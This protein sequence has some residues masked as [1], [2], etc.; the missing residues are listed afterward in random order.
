[1]LKKNANQLRIPK[2]WVD[3]LDL[4]VDWIVSQIRDNDKIMKAFAISTKKIAEDKN[5]SKVKKRL[6]M[7]VI[8]NE[9][10]D[11]FLVDFLKKKSIVIKIKNKLV[12]DYFIMKE[13]KNQSVHSKKDD[14]D[15][16]MKELDELLDEGCQAPK[17]FID[18]IKLEEYRSKTKSDN[19]ALMR[20]LY[21]EK[22]GR[23]RFRYGKYGLEY[24]DRTGEE[25]WSYLTF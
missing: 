4:E 6:R 25:P 18:P 12:L 15:S 2:I 3:S 17:S 11:L 1:M 5:I 24:Y 20:Y 10:M 21:Y 8:K 14:F 7:E 9:Y 19:E 13:R 16:I 23:D 22:T